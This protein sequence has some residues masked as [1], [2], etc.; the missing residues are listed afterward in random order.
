MTIQKRREDAQDLLQDLT[1]CGQFFA[2]DF[3]KRTTGED[4][5][6]NGKSIEDSLD[7]YDQ[8]RDLMTIFDAQAGHPK[9]VNL[10]GL[11]EIRAFGNTYRFHSHNN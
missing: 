8:E 6:L 7:D 3:V 2:V 1:A 10:R 11:K 9:S 4:R 5:T